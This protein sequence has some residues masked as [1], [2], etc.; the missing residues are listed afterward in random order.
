MSGGDFDGDGNV[1]L[2]TANSTTEPGFAITIA[3]GN[4][5]GTFQR[6]VSYG[7]SV[8]PV[9][10][11][12]LAAGDFN[13]DGKLDVVV[14]SAAGLAVFQGNG[15]GTFGAPILTADAS[16][17][18]V[19]AG[20]A[21]LDGDGST[22]LITVRNSAPLVWL[23]NGDG[24]F[25]AAQ[26]ADP[27]GNTYARTMVFDVNGDSI[28]DLVAGPTSASQIGVLLGNG[29][30]TFQAPLV[31]TVTTAGTTS[32]TLGDFNGDHKTDLAVLTQGS[33]SVFPGD[34]TGYFPQPLQGVGTGAVGTAAWSGD[35]NGD[36]KLDVISAF[37]GRQ[38]YLGNGDGTLG[39]ASYTNLTIEPNFLVAG[40][41]DHDGK[42]DF[43]EA[44]SA[45]GFDVW[46]GRQVDGLDIS[47]THTGN[48]ISGG[49]GSYQISVLNLAFSP[50]QGNITVADVL[51]SSMTA[52]LWIGPSWSW[53]CN[54]ASLTCSIPS[55]NL[56]T[57][58]SF[59]TI[60]LNVNV[61]AGLP[62]STVE[63]LVSVTAGSVVT[64][65]TDPTRIVPP[66]STVLG[67][68]PSPSTFGS[69]VTL[70][71]TVDAGATG[72]V[73]FADGGTPLGVSQ[74]SGSQ[75]T[76][77]TNALSSGLRS[78][79]GAYSGDNNHGPSV[80]PAK[81]HTV[82]PLP[83]NG[84][85][86]VTALSPGSGPRAVV[87][88]DVNHDGK[89][90]LITA[91][92]GDGTVSVLLSNG[93]GTFQSATN[94]AVGAGPGVLTVSDFNGDGE[95]DIVVGNQT[96]NEIRILL[97]NGN[98]TFQP[99]LR[100]SSLHQPAT[101]LS[102]DGNADNHVDLF[103][104]TYTGDSTLYTGL[105]NADY[106]DYTYISHGQDGTRFALADLDRDGNTEVVYFSG[107]VVNWARFASY[108]STP[109]IALVH[110]LL[111]DI[112]VG[113]LDMDGKLD[114]VASD[115]T[116][117]YVF[118]GNGDGTVSS[119][120][121]YATGKNASRILLADIDGDGKLGR[122]HTQSRL[123]RLHHSK[124]A[125][126]RHPGCRRGVHH[127]HVPRLHGRRRPQQR[128]PRRSDGGSC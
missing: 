37:V 113:D 107:P 19:A 82:K 73:L 84:F 7:F 13:R 117:V 119:Q 90:D 111:H 66:S 8:N 40:D 106:Y 35:F 118:P 71:A 42:P 95:P 43:A 83:A 32:F 89:P 20:A 62:A 11:T 70:T 59:V 86:T 105:F 126:R 44:S 5:D 1:D 120:I 103:A 108:R 87:S 112:A 97:G 65:A 34:G 4:A 49:T 110:T 69:S 29:D 52:S 102:L 79:T 93:N 31:S 47:V 15:D 61:Q 123:K 91:N 22:D 54:Q 24:T 100:I 88:A 21:D 109:E 3:M 127:G 116:G 81:L 46:L 10:P 101:L 23:C 75:A 53:Q 9:A 45:Y 27:T 17:G 48:F 2:V 28:P 76:L 96:A 55:L 18:G 50:F 115:D 6:G 30:G 36:G 114:I 80:S 124:G 68:S 67:V 92:S 12:G 60:A 78:L 72:T 128:W 104:A 26:S 99:A 77:T 38:M 121:H 85:P 64:S 58:D 51:P 33:V 14:T 125:R 39:R 122:R 25:H 63:N 74:L 41:F 56:A 94:Y 98:G 57:G 16:G